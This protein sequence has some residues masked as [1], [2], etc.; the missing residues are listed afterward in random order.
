MEDNQRNEKLYQLRKKKDLRMRL[1]DRKTSEKLI[2]I[3]LKKTTKE[4]KSFYLIIP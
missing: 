1:A 4:K 3:K 2:K